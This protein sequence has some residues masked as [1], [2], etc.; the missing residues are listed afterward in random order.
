M[1]A[2]LGMQADLLKQALGKKMT[3]PS[4]RR[5][6]PVTAVAKRGVGIAPA[7]RTFGVSESCYRGSPKRGG[8]NEEI[9]DLLIGLTNARKT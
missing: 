8:E 9:A 5:E 7:C 2:D 1:Y 4:L 6:M 3:R